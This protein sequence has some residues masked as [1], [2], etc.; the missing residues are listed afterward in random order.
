MTKYRPFYRLIYVYSKMYLG[1][2]EVAVPDLHP[3]QV[4][5][6]QLKAE[7]RVAG[8][9]TGGTILALISTGELPSVAEAICF[10]P[11]RNDTMALAYSPKPI[12]SGAGRSLANLPQKTRV[13]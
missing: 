9:Y 11:R 5:L 4:P 10:M 1:T 7:A 2:G 3:A 12:Q 8:N 6:P 13:R